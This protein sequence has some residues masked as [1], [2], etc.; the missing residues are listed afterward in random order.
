MIE[1]HSSHH[2]ETASDCLAKDGMFWDWLA[3]A[4]SRCHL[5]TTG[6]KSTQLRQV[7]PRMQQYCSTSKKIVDINW[8]RSQ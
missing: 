2:V 4:R 6:P 3:M 8:K 1:T 5:G 7:L